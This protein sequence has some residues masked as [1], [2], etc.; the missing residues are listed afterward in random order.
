MEDIV[1]Y[2][3][4]CPVCLMLEQKLKDKNI[5]FKEETNVEEIKKLGFKTVPIL[6]VDNNYFKTLDAIKYLENYRGV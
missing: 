4:H 2:T 5:K 3:T 1:L 6:K